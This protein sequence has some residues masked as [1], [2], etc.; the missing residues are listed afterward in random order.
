MLVLFFFGAVG[1]GVWAY[2]QRSHYKDHSDQE[3]ATA[4]QKATADQKTAD[5]ATYAE[6]AKKPYDTYIGPAA[7]G[8]I[9]VNYPKTWSAYTIENERGGNPISAYFQPG[10]VPSV[11]DEDNAF[12]L[13]VELVQT[14][15][16]T[17]LGQFKALLTANKVTVA[18][19]TLP[20][21]PSIVG[22]R[23]EGQIT[24]TKQGTMVVLPLRN[25]TLKIWTESNDFKGDL[26]THILPN[27]T[28][29][30]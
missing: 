5:A 29:V 17:V 22:S 24:P 8:N 10:T 26:D 14:P 4:V 23:I 30:P 9:T 12:A 18:P 1:F 27:L 15:Y 6:Q 16:D 20:K 25:L 13:R 19:Y 2:G 3:V 11:I 28:F 7:F 21:V